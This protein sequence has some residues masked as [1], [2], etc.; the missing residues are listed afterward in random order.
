MPMYLKRD[1]IRLLEASVES[2]SLAVAALGLPRR[3]ESREPASEN[4]IAIGLAGVSAELAMSA[5]IVQAKGEQALRFPSNFYKTGSHIVDDFR[6]LITSQIP[7]MVFLTQNGRVDKVIYILVWANKKDAMRRHSAYFIILF[8][9]MAAADKRQ[10]SSAASMPRR[11]TRVKLC[12][13]FCAANVPSHQICRS[14][15]A[16]RYSGL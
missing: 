10:W 5:I 8:R 3:Y 7:K 14:F 11:K 4:S 15:S 2:I 1:T 6:L 13:R 9:F 12:P 16:S